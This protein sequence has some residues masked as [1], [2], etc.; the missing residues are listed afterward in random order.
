MSNMCR[1]ASIKPILCL[2]LFQLGC[3]RHPSLGILTNCGPSNLRDQKYG[4]P[5]ISYS[6]PMFPGFLRR[7]HV[8]YFS[9]HNHRQ[10]QSQS[11]CSAFV[12]FILQLWTELEGKH[13]LICIMTLTMTM[14]KNKEWELKKETKVNSEFLFKKEFRNNFCFYLHLT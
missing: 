12:M 2:T 11:L 3:R 7:G 8:F 9:F 4:F 13:I 5:E 14:T 6:H 10:S 1:N